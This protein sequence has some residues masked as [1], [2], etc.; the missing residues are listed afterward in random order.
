MES[1]I[2]YPEEL[3]D[4]RSDYPLGP[5]RVAVVAETMSPHTNELFRQVYGLKP[6]Q[7]V[8]DEKVQ[9]LLLTLENKEK[10]TA[11]VALL[12]FYIE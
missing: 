2:E 9:K 1:D 12:Q 10:S 5:T 6:H 11:H 8:P 4:S 7:K 3:H